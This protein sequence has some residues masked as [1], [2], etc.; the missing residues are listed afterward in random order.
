MP[1]PS[2]RWTQPYYSGTFDLGGAVPFRPNGLVLLGGGALGPQMSRRS[3]DK[4][5]R[6]TVVTERLQTANGQNSA[7]LGASL[8][9]S[10]DPL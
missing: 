10:T 8:A 3:A 6:R 7:S 1:L 5:P 9:F 4:L 2:D